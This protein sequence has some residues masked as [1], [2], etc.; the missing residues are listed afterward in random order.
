MKTHLRK[1][2]YGAFPAI[3]DVRWTFSSLKA[4][5]SLLK[6]RPAI[7]AHL[8]KK[9]KQNRRVLAH[10]RGESKNRK[11]ISERN[12]ILKYIVD[13]LQSVQLIGQLHALYDM[14]MRIAELS[15]FLQTAL[16]TPP[17]IFSKVQECIL[18]LNQFKE[19]FGPS[20]ATFLDEITDID[21]KE[22]LRNSLSNFIGTFVDGITESI[23]KHFFE[24][25]MIRNCSVL[26]PVSFPKDENALRK[27]GN[28]EVGQLA[29]KFGDENFAFMVD[30][31]YQKYKLSN[32]SIVGDNLQLLFHYIDVLP[33]STAACER[34]FSLMNTIWNERSNRFEPETVNHLL[35]IQC[36]GGDAQDVHEGH[37]I[38]DFLQDHV[39]ATKRN[40]ITQF[41]RKNARSDNAI[42][43]SRNARKALF[44]Y[45]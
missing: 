38:V 9:I 40:D 37:F 15:L 18:R 35:T 10:A 12:S 34:G 11:K 42:V 26:S 33:F 39:D 2:R 29:L 1:L 5:E 16:L 23:N 22:E 4:A 43:V 19:S 32:A 24:S 17:S 13:R 30:R 27:Y 31:E 41:K 21:V 3:F 7:L 36:N 25:M 8:T 14:L 6:N 28:T 20:L 44:D 45:A